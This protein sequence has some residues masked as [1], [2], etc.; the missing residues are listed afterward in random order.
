MFFIIFIV[1]IFFSICY[2]LIGNYFFN[3]ALNP[4]ISKRYILRSVTEEDKK[5]EMKYKIY[6]EKWLNEF[7]KEVNIISEDNLKLHG[8]EVENPIKKSHIW[9]ILVHGYM[10]GAYE[11]VQYAKEFINERI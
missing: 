3:I 11:M 7:A 4:K 2:L 9:V 5:N 6:G 10:G 1:F 8:Y